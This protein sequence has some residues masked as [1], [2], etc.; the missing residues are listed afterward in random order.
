MVEL[1]WHGTKQMVHAEGVLWLGAIAVP[2][3]RDLVRRHVEDL[4]RL[5]ASEEKEEKGK[6]RTLYLW[7]KWTSSRCAA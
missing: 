4:A 2:A 5:F 7:G 6:E 1:E 3:T